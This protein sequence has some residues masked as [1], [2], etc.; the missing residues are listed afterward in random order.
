MAVSIRPIDPRPQTTRLQ[1]DALIVLRWSVPDP[2]RVCNPVV[3]DFVVEDP[4]AHAEKPRG[5]FLNPVR[6][7]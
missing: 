3:F 6:L 1:P 2:R 5:I 7:S 4:W